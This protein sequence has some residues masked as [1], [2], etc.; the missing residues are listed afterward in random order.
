MSGAPPAS[1]CA[2][3]LKRRARRYFITGWPVA[4][5]NAYAR[6]ERDT[7]H[8]FAMALSVS[9]R[10]E[11]RSMTQRALSL[12]DMIGSLCSVKPI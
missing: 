10:S 2:A 3:S 12:I 1:A 9:E 7:P 5:P 4:V 8:A 6:C 11:L